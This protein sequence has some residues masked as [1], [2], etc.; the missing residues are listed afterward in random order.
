[1]TIYPE[2][3]RNLVGS[4]PRSLPE[5]SSAHGCAI[6]ISRVDLAC[7]PALLS[8]PAAATEEHDE[9]CKEQEDHSRKDCPHAN[10]ED[11]M[12]ARTVIV[13]VIFDNARP[14]EISDHDDKCDEE[15]DSCNHRCEQR[16]DETSAQCEQEGDECQTA[17]DGMED[18]NSCERI[19]GVAASCAE[20]CSVD[21]GHDSSWVI[22]DGSWVAVVLIS[23]NWCDIENAV[24]E[25]P[26]CNGG[27]TDVGEVGQCDL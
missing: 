25:S 27:I 9:G 26:K 11:G 12:A 16:A 20:A 18:L 6:G 24:T 8:P 14:Y 10:A 2:D 22:A 3:E 15:C 5:M 4:S 21:G 13:D 7:G 17:G 1:L 19:G 23:L